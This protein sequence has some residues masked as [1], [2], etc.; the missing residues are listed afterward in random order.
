MLTPIT[1]SS[2]LEVRHLTDENFT[3]AVVNTGDGLQ[4]VPKLALLLEG[5]KVAASIV[6]F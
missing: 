5:C 1:V 2:T 6:S 3:V 4:S